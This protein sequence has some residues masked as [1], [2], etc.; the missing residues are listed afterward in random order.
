MTLPLPVF[1]L[2]KICS[3]CTLNCYYQRNNTFY[4]E[5][6]GLLM[7]S[8]SGVFTCI[9]LAFLKSGLFKYIIPCNSNYFRYIDNILLIYLQE[10]E[11]VKI[12]DRLNKIEPTLK[13]IHE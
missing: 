10:F 5:K 4:K 3:L 7:G 6:F 9:Y 11:L 12:T 2:I 13:F 8:L 1:K